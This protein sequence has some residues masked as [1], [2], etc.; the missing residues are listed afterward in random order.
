MKLV[1]NY[2]KNCISPWFVVKMEGLGFLEDPD[3][4]STLLSFLLSIRIVSVLH[5]HT[6]LNKKRR[7][8]ILV[9]FILDISKTIPNHKWH[10]EKV[11]T[12]EHPSLEVCNN[13]LN[14][15]LS[16]MENC[17]WAWLFS[18]S[19]FAVI[20]GIQRKKIWL[21][22]QWTPSFF[23]TLKREEPCHWFVESGTYIALRIKAFITSNASDVC[24]DHYLYV[25]FI[26]ASNSCNHN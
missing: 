2:M 21:Q 3:L 11:T 13:S 26:F 8:Y 24:E 4:G 7:A 19:L 14:K 16:G 6:G 25:S 17:S 18:P 22:M 15:H 1:Q 9:R 5:A 10:K 12:A 20:K 23:L